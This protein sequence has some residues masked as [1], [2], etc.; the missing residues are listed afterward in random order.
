VEIVD[1]GQDVL[2]GKSVVEDAVGR[3]LKRKRQLRCRESSEEGQ[4]QSCERAFARTGL[5]D[6]EQNK[7]RLT[8]CQRKEVIERREE[9]QRQ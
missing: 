9:G 8:A 5:A 7:L 1:A 3:I 6:Q 4:H 2:Q